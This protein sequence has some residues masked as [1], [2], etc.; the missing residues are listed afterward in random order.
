MSAVSRLPVVVPALAAD[1]VPP[2]LAQSLTGGDAAALGVALAVGLLLGLQRERSQRAT[3]RRGPAGAR[4]FPI[5]SLLGAVAALLEGGH[6]GWLTVAGFLAVA[7]LTAAAYVRTSRDGAAVGLTTEVLLLLAYVLGA[8]AGAGRVEEATVVGAVALLLVSLKDR[9]HAFAGRLTPEDETAFLKF[10]AVALLALPLLPDVDVGP[11]GAL[12]AADVGRMVVLVAGVSFVGYVAV[13][14]VGADRGLLVTGLLGGLVSTTATTVAFARRSREH[15]ALSGPLASG[16]VAGCA[17]LYPRVV[18]LVAVVSPAFALR[19]VPWL[20]PMAAVTLVAALPGLLAARRGAT[21][22][23]PLRNPFEL[24]PALWFALLYAL[25]VLVAR[26]AHETLGS[27]GLYVAGAL[28]GTTD[29][30]A[31]AL[32]AA[33]LVGDGSDAPQRVVVVAAVANAAVKAALAWTL[34]SRAYGRRVAVGLLGSA[35]AG[36]LTL[37]VA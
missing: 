31:I 22:D 26:A 33:R 30:D 32:T 37:L 11:Y 6:P 23:V 12:N 15:D 36:L 13:K 14:T 4:T 17:V 7:A 8:A 28:A 27:A 16:A 29:L 10:V 25:V 35:A 1:A 5:V 3:G 2:P 18:A 20:A 19:V 9:L 24:A 21:A 34:G